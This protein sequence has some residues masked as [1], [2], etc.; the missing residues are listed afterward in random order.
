MKKISVILLIATAIAGCRQESHKKVDVSDI[1]VN[2][3]ILPFHKDFYE[4]KTH[5]FEEQERYLI[6]K[7]GAFYTFYVED[8]MRKFETEN[9]EKPLK[10]NILAFLSDSNIQHLYDS[11]NYHFPNTKK[12]EN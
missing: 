1:Q 11:V 3:E 2:V 10:Q 8:L 4:L 12:I 6:N 7:Y 5:N 9:S